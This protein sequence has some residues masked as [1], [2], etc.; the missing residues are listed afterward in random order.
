[1][2]TVSSNII[3]YLL[4]NRLKVFFSFPLGWSKDIALGRALYYNWF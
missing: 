3:N 2:G 1:M 4:Y